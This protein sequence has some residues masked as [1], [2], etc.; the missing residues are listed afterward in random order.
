MKRK[1]I[2]LLIT[3]LLLSACGCG[4]RAGAQGGSDRPPFADLFGKGDKGESG[5][6]SQTIPEADGFI[7]Y[8]AR[9][10]HAFDMKLDLKGV[11]GFETFAAEAESLKNQG[12]EFLQFGMPW[13]AEYFLTYSLSGV[14]SLRYAADCLLTGESKTALAENDGNSFASWDAV[15]SIA[16]ASPCPMMLEAI[17]ADKLGDTERSAVCSELA[18]LNPNEFAGSEAFAAIADMDE[19]D[20][21]DLKAGLEEYE[22]GLLAVWPVIP[23]A[24]PRT[25]Y[26]FSVPYQLA[27]AAAFENEGQPE[28]AL[29]AYETAIR[30]DPMDPELFLYAAVASLNQ[31][32][33]EAAVSYVNEGLLLDENY[34]PL[35]VLSAV[36]KYGLG[37]YDTAKEHIAKA[38]SLEQLTPD[39][40]AICKELEEKMGGA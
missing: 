20:L 4:K 15:G 21:K 5:S 12:L 30:V 35:H 11:K 26:E 33:G 7:D 25:G 23:D 3:V 28:N 16:P 38:R 36:L 29:T 34:A 19:A 39:S 18:A 8:N 27:L 24:F 32:D 22:T 2:F 9:I 1:C 10:E 6:G 31:K 13:Q 40:E 17:V 14:S 37:D